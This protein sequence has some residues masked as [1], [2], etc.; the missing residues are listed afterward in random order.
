MPG[1]CAFVQAMGTMAK[2][3]AKTDDGGATAV[4]TI[5]AGHGQQ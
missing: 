4:I 2:A 3:L 5:A 1:Y